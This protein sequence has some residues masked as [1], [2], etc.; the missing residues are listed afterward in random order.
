MNAQIYRTFR[1]KRKAAGKTYRAKLRRDMFD[2]Y[3]ADLDI[4]GYDK[5]GREKIEDQEQFD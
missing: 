4:P 5:T 2:W 3:Y 1:L